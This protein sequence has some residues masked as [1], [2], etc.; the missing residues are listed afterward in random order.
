MENKLPD[1]QL[2]SW[3]NKGEPL[4]LAHSAK[5]WWERVYS[6]LTFP[7]AQIDV[8]TCD[9][10]LLNLLAYQRDVMRFPSESLSLYR[11]R[12]KH[13][14]INSQDAGSIA[15][16]ERIFERLEIGKIQQL[17]R[18][19][20]LDWDVIVIRINDEQLSRDNDLMM[21]LVR[22]YGRTCRRYFFDV[23]NHT[24][25]YAHSGYF[26]CITYYDSAKLELRPTAIIP[27]QDIV[28]LLP[29]EERT[30][31]VQVKPEGVNDAS[32]TATSNGHETVIYSII[33]NSI[34]L[35]ALTFGTSEIILKTN[36]G[37]QTTTITAKV[38]AGAKVDANYTSI[39]APVFFA[40]K[41]FDDPEKQIWFDWGD[42]QQ[43][44]NYSDA[45]QQSGF[46]PPRGVWKTGEKHTVTIYNSEDVTFKSASSFNRIIKLHKV[47]G[48]RTE[49][50]YFLYQQDKLTT[51]ADDAFAYLPNLQSIRYFLAQT[52]ITQ[53]PSSL[54]TQ[55][56]VIE[57]ASYAFYYSNISQLP[58]GFLQKA[59]KLRKT[60]NMLNRNPIT[61]IDN[62]TFKACAD[63][64]EDMEDMLAFCNQLE[65]DVNAIFSANTYSK[66]RVVKDGFYGCTKLKGK[67][68]AFI[69]KCKVAQRARLFAGCTSLSDYE[70][71]PTGWK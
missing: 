2:P 17:E 46:N 20:Q 8:D 36:V 51:I 3:M 7:L 21:N 23:L 38:V 64:L 58:K 44:T 19:L 57:D 4:T 48:L 32:F 25:T 6:W 9:E 11:L 69:E 47:A 54:L 33:E 37:E 55:E 27:S 22:Q 39:N 41:Y 26:D 43:T 29:G 34:T 5:R 61:H 52:N 56:T 14:F 62:D 53:L 16:F 68:A 30:I 71:L 1:I 70:D 24:V 12:V 15:G 35:K 45:T 28:W 59:S 66:L 67:G 40:S 10:Q 13:A 65:S 31:T 42:G 49:L 63:S 60:T 18:Q 50:D